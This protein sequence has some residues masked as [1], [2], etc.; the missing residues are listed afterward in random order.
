MKKPSPRVLSALAFP[1]V[2]L[3]ACSSASSHL[4]TEVAPDGKYDSEFPTR[5]ASDVLERVADLVHRFSSISFYEGYVFTEETKL[6]D[7][8][9]LSGAYKHKAAQTFTFSNSTAGTATIIYAENKKLA[10]LTC[11]HI[12]DYPD[13]II[14]YYDPGEGDTPSH[15][16]SFSLKKRQRNFLSE[17]TQGSELEI[18][19]LDRDLDIAVLGKDLPPPTLREIGVIDFP[20]GSAKELHWGDFVYI[21]GYPKGNKMVTRGIISKPE[22]GKKHQFMID[23][24]FNRGFSG[25]IVMAIRDGI[26]NLELVGMVSSV[27]ATTEQVLAPKPGRQTTQ[28][29]PKLPYTEEIYIDNQMRIDYGITYAVSIEAVQKF[30]KENRRTFENQGYRFSRFFHQ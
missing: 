5:D 4:I 3:L 7:A 22:R 12:V 27:S 11:A 30:L 16:E 18:L 21:M 25:G 8:D 9:V 2:L 23:A 26:P 17:I 14:T 19:A 10:I 15:I 28:Y 20:L 13:T 24:L 29:H 6:T 1:L